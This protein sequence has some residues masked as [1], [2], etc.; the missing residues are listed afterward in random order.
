MLFTECQKKNFVQNCTRL[1]FRILVAIIMNFGQ[2]LR[3]FDISLKS[4]L[5]SQFWSKLAEIWTRLSLNN[6]EE[7]QEAFLKTL[8][9]SGFMLIFHKKMGNFA[10]F[11]TKN[12]IIY[13]NI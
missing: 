13:N 2:K 4:C 5:V 10:N 11:R 6:L 1:K 7:N 3:F 8:I 9:Y 12:S